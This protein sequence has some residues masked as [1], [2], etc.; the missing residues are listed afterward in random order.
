MYICISFFLSLFDVFDCFS[1][2][3][4]KL[5]QNKTHSNEKSKQKKLILIYFPP[6]FNFN[7]FI[8]LLLYY[9]IM[10]PLKKY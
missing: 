5:Q 4:S 1:N 2:L 6:S 8:S 7:F 10:F 9:L 3:L